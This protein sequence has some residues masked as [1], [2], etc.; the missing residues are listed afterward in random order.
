MP[1]TRLLLIALIPLI[2]VAALGAAYALIVESRRP[3]TLSGDQIGEIALRYEDMPPEY[4]FD[5]AYSGPITYQRLLA[6]GS[7]KTAAYMGSIDGLAGYRTSFER[8]HTPD[9][10]QIVRSYVLM[11]PDA[12]TAHDYFTVHPTLFSRLE[13]QSMDFPTLA[14]ESVALQATQGGDALEVYHVVMR[15]RN[16]VAYLI[17]AAAAGSAPEGELEGY[18]RR[19][20]ERLIDTVAQ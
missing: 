19:L 2:V 1:R 12:R 11:Y 15:Q 6:Y 10:I 8:L 13:L 9:D 16:V 4:T 17:Y 7:Q 20:E 5:A 18:A 14:E 3:V